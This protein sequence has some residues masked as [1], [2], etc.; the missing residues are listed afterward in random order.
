MSSTLTRLTGGDPGVSPLTLVLDCDR[1]DPTCIKAD[2]ALPLAAALKEYRELRKRE[3]VAVQFHF[4]NGQR[5]GEIIELDRTPH[6]LRIMDAETLRVMEIPD[7]GGCVPPSWRGLPVEHGSQYAH[8]LNYW[9]ETLGLR[10]GCVEGQDRTDSELDRSSAVMDDCEE[11][12]KGSTPGPSLA[13]GGGASRTLPE[14]GA[15]GVLIETVI[16]EIA[17]EPKAG[18]AAFMVLQCAHPDPLESKVLYCSPRVPDVIGQGQTDMV[19][20]PWRE[21]YAHVTPERLGHWRKLTDGL[22]TVGSRFALPW[23]QAGEEHLV[24]AEPLLYL[25]EDD[26]VELL[27]VAINNIS[28]LP[29]GNPGERHD[30]CSG[31]F[32]SEEYGEEEPPPLR[33]VHSALD[34]QRRVAFNVKT[35]FSDAIIRTFPL[36]E[37]YG[38]FVNRTRLLDRAYEKVKGPPPNTSFDDDSDDLF[39]EN[40]TAICEVNPELRAYFQLQ[41]IASRRAPHACFRDLIAATLVIEFAGRCWGIGTQSTTTGL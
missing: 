22:E 26:T 8:T 29:L 39:T 41:R 11:E 17:R 5:L 34:Y 36:Y 28:N 38:T 30:D 33:T 16:A 19:G 35:F 31:K 2:P 23:A 13:E 10:G 1:A 27:C 20:R 32:L 37:A 6:E 24:Y 40:V 14:A 21:V 3:G 4:S 18:D 25:E 7:K 12:N 9:M 15:F